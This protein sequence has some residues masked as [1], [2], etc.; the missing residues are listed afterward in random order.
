MFS[1]FRPYPKHAHVHFCYQFSRTVALNPK[2]NVYNNIYKSF[3]SVLRNVYIRWAD[4]AELLFNTKVE[5]KKTIEKESFALLCA[6][7]DLY[8]PTYVPRSSGLL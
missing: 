3:A 8:T 1:P 4:I 7:S 6:G 2:H 5:K